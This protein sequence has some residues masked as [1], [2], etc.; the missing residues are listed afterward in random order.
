MTSPEI[1]SSRSTALGER[2]TNPPPTQFDELL[3]SRLFGLLERV[4]TLPIE[5][6][7][8]EL[9]SLVK[10]VNAYRLNVD[11]LE[12]LLNSTTT[13]ARRLEIL[14]L[15]RHQRV[16]VAENRA[17]LQRLHEKSE[18]ILEHSAQLLAKIDRQVYEQTHKNRDYA[19][20]IC[21]SCSGVGKIAGKPCLSC[22]SRRTV[23]VHQP[24]I[25]VHAVLGPATPA[26]ATERSFRTIFA[27]FVG[28]RAGFWCR[29]HD[30]RPSGEFLEIFLL[31]CGFN[32]LSTLYNNS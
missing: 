26:L 21:A 4:G 12:T 15:L 7:K 28:A 14:E 29:T 11:L 9:D 17:E 18:S 22:D 8:S 23:L 5:D 10:L 27:S 25:S 30:L 19:P 1:I 31:W 20:E 2:S 24:P 3:E 32:C 13:V 6:V 16:K